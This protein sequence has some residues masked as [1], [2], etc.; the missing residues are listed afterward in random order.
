M[1]EVGTPAGKSRRSSDNDDLQMSDAE[2]QKSGQS[3]DD[4]ND[5]T[6]K[7][8]NHVSS[9]GG[10]QGSKSPTSSSIENRKMSVAALLD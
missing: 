10:R 1:D 2:V 6:P 7:L 5:A 8:S 4:D 3:G 9:N